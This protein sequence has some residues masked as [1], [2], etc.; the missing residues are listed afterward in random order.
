MT[1]LGNILDVV[2]ILFWYKTKSEWKYL[3]LGFRL[4]PEVL[5]LSSTSG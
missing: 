5:V 4:V 2:R 3:S 1:S